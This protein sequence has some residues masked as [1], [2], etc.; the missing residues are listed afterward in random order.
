MTPFGERAKLHIAVRSQ[1]ECPIGSGFGP[2]VAQSNS[3][4][5]WTIGITVPEAS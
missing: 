4:T 2:P 1:K 3:W 5:V